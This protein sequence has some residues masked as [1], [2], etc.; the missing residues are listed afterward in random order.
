MLRMI[1]SMASC[2]ILDAM[3]Q[4]I[5]KQLADGV[6]TRRVGLVSTG[7]PARAHSDITTP[8]GEKARR[9]YYVSDVSVWALG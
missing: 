4:V 6:T 7:A 2:L 8:D 3:R 9:V 5:K 1:T